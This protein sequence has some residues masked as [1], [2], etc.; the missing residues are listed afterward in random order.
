MNFTI[1]DNYLTVYLAGRIDSNNSAAIE[2]EVAS[3]VA[4]N[5]NCE[6]IFDADKLIYISSAGLR[7]LLKFRKKSAKKISV[8][9]VSKEIYDVFEMTGFARIFDVQKKLRNVSIDGCEEVGSGLSSKVYRLDADTI[10][11]VYEKRVPMYKIT[12]EIDLAKKA[13][14]AGIPTAISYD[15]VRCGENFGVVFE[16]I[17]NAK[18][19]G[20]ALAE[21]NGKNF[22]QIMK[23]FAEMMKSM[24]HTKV[25]EQDG[26]PSIKNT[27]FEWSDGMKKFYT[28]DESAKIEKMLAAVPDRDT[29]VHCDFHA[30][31]TMYQDGE[32]VV[33]DMA[34]VGYA[35][36]IFDF[37]AGAFHNMFRTRSEIQRALN[38]SENNINRFWNALLANY[39]QISPEKLDEIKEIFIAF[40]YLRSALFP[41]KHVQ[42]SDELKQ[43]YVNNARKNFFSNIDWAIKQSERLKTLEM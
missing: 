38:L 39:F 3:I 10:V 21:D 5:P 31:N 37:A 19:V 27:W 12:R 30:G 32:I 40:A 6:P 2:K 25:N 23:K 17:A 34:D 1:T 4:A 22:D 36:P 16:M 26:F 41:M 20:K 28:A 15:I 13:F 29:I 42:I 43:I 14:L 24:H 11:K 7:F 33:I 9:N 35:H 8:I 18:T